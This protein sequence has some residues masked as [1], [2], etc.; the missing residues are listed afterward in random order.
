MLWMLQRISGRA[1]ANLIVDLMQ[2]LEQRSSCAGDVHW[3]S[4]LQP[5]T[6]AGTVLSSSMTSQIDTK[7]TSFPIHHV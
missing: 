4:L 7:A 2:A 6:L 3:Y 5:T 1:D